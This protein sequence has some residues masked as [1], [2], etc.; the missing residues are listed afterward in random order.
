M[1]SKSM[2]RWMMQGTAD[3]DT[4]DDA[5]AAIRWVDILK[6][7]LRSPPVNARGIKRCLADQPGDKARA[8]PN[9][10]RGMKPQ[11]RHCL[12]AGLFVIARFQLVRGL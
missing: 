7:G 5:Q 1:R 8:P 6:G 10:D 4:V 11:E 12:D 3:D 2:T 9:I